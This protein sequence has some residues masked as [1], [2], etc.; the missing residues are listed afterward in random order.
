[1]SPRDGRRGGVGCAR[2]RVCTRV[3]E[4]RGR[5]ALRGPRMGLGWRR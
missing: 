1:V 4:Q 2:I 5:E 3:A